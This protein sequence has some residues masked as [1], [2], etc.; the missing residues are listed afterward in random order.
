LFW[1]AEPTS[2]Y[3]QLR[4]FSQ[5]IYRLT[6]LDFPAPDTFTYALDFIGTYTWEE[7]CQGWVLRAAARR[8]L[9][10]S[11]DQV[12]S[13]WTK[14]AHVGVVGINRMDKTLLLGECM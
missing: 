3:D 10:V 12:G 2:C 9:P 5:A 11:P 6:T 13:A 14:T 8:I 1:V 7:L 4:S